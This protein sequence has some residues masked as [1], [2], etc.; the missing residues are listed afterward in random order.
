MTPDNHETVMLLRRDVM[1]LAAR[2]QIMRDHM[3]MADWYSFVREYPDASNWFDQNGVPVIQSAKL[4][5]VRGE[6]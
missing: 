1:Q 2:L 6:T 4:E 5:S 3:R